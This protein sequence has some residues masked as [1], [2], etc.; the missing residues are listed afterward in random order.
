MAR[1]YKKRVRVE[2]L[3]ALTVV[4]LLYGG[5]LLWRYHAGRRRAEELQP[6]QEELAGSLAEPRTQLS[7]E[8]HK[9]PS[10]SQ[11]NAAA[12][13]VQLS[14]LLEEDPQESRQR[15]DTFMERY[16]AWQVDGN[17]QFPRGEPFLRG[18]VAPQ[19]GSIRPYS[20]AVPEGYDAE[21]PTALI[22]SLPAPGAGETSASVYAGAI[23][24]NPAAP[25]VAAA[26]LGGEAYVL[27]VVEDVRA[28]Y[29]IDPARIYVTGQGTGGTSAWHL[30][31]HYP[32]LF[33]GVA[34]FSAPTTHEVWRT[35]GEVQ[36]GQ[37][38]ALREF[39]RS[40]R[41]PISYATNLSHTPSA[42]VHATGDAVVPVEHARRMVAALREH[43][44]PTYYREFPE[45]PADQLPDWARSEALGWL[46]GRL[47]QGTPREFTY[48]TADLGH[49]RAWWVRLDRLGHP[50]AF[51]RVHARLQDGVAVLDVEN[52]EAASVLLD[53]LPEPVQ[54]IRIG[55]AEFNV[56]GRSGVISFRQQGDAW[57]AAEPPQSGKR[58]GVSGPLCQVFEDQFVIVYGTA[59]K[60]SLMRAVCEREALRFARRWQRIYGKEPRMVSDE[61]LRDTDWRDAHV[62][63]IGGP[64]ANKQTVRFTQ[65]WPVEFTEGAFRMAGRTYRDPAEGLLMCRPNPQRPGRLVALAHGNSAAALYQSLDRFGLWLTYGVSLRSNWFDFGVFDA[66]TADPESFLHVGYF[67]NEWQLPG[68][69]SGQ[70]S[71]GWSLR[72]TGKLPFGYRAQGFPS[73]LTVTD[74][75]RALPVA[76]GPVYLSDLM[77]QRIDQP[78]GAV[79]FDRAYTGRRIRVGGATFEKGLGVAAPSEISYHVGGLFRRFSST[80]ALSEGFKGPPKGARMEGEKVVF[81]LWGDG[82]LLT[83]SPVLSWS[84]R[85]AARIHADIRGVFDL[86]LVVRPEGDLPAWRY[87][88]AAWCAPAIRR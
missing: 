33:S 55:G 18:Y 19:D 2:F 80:V 86:K 14:R 62:V 47:P 1:R 6:L 84:G 57:T 17:P 38:A 51:S 25:G 83:T 74:A 3:V 16:Q 73:A 49:N 29:N 11:R 53:E 72:R 64:E 15:L 54:A 79:G 36:E 60:S 48:V 65:G 26:S 7:G 42:A 46:F 32:H 41:W 30:A 24:V 76:G 87:G 20:I 5:A 75:L 56:A 69:E 45:A 85:S 27:A 34:A 37:A 63:L 61:N 81:E 23:A 77:P 4:V 59:G 66:H 71:G 31:A 28:L 22:V 78:Q 44:V 12:L 58:P 13:A 21:T 50:L 70:G 68:A 9:P 10:R 35:D 8:A 88:A 40:T 67:D 43:G 39:L 52:V 82:N